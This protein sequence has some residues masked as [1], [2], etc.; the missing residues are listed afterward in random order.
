MRTLYSKK[1]GGASGELRSRGD[2]VCVSPRPI[3]RLAGP[4]VP[5]LLRRMFSWFLL[6]RRE[7]QP[8]RKGLRRGYSILSRGIWLANQSRRRVRRAHRYRTFVVYNRGPNRAAVEGE[9]AKYKSKI[10]HKTNRC[11]SPF[12]LVAIRMCA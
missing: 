7:H 6:P 8:Q 12:W 11:L 10:K 3:R 1:G 9:M 4:I 2:V 5:P